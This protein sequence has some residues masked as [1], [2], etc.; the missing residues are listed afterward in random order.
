M[1]LG[2]KAEQK[3]TLDDGAWIVQCCDFHCHNHS[4]Q[5]LNGYTW[6]QL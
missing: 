6:V 3:A 1:T 4:Q 5:G 2:S